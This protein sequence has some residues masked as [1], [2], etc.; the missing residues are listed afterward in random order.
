MG[1]QLSTMRLRAANY[2]VLLVASLGQ[3]LGQGLATLVGIVIPMLQLSVPSELP[4]GLQGI[5]G[6]ISLIGIMIGSAVIGNLC[7]RFGYLWLFR[8]C[9]VVCG[10]AA[11]AVVLF[12]HVWVLIAALFVMGFAVG[13]EYSLDPNYIAELMPAKWKQFMV[14]VAK[15]FASAG[16]V[17]VAAI[18]YVVLRHGAPAR[19][20]PMLMLI[21]VG[22]CALMFVC[23][24]GFA[25]SPVWLA[26]H[27]RPDQARAAVKKMLGADVEMDNIAEAIATKGAPAVSIWKF[28]GTHFRQVVLT[29]LPWACEG[30]GV[31]G[32]GIFLPV[33][34]M[35][36]GLDPASP[37]ADPMECITASVWL[38]FVLC[39]V[40]MAGFILG[41]SVLKRIPHL[42]MQIWGFVICSAGLGVLL[43]AYLL[44]WHIWVAIAGFV[45]FEVALNA[46]PHLITFVLPSQVFTS[47]DRGT[48]AG[49]AASVGKSGAVV[50]AFCIPVILSRW[51]AEG[52][53]TTSIT[54]MLLGAVIT[55]IFKS[56]AQKNN[57]PVN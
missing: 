33:L 41:L 42:R 9:P 31:Y 52:V 40:M 54:V 43:G 26:R 35:A 32:I 29:G 7:D 38:T 19:A 57:T 6:C 16:G 46:G 14:G 27:G 25:Q 53:L 12:P 55:W 2:K 3:F 23:R 1:V 13:G 11:L 48:G 21:V 20:W 56:A 15:A 34:I 45:L 4:S 22:L 8:A 49:I 17:F 51:G 5:L 30:L 28:V 39:I 47:S 37:A 18:C 10:A 50:G 36:F 44:R 24:L